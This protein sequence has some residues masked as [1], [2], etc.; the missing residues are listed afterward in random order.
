VIFV[1]LWELVFPPKEKLS[2]DEMEEERLAL[3]KNEEVMVG[4]DKKQQ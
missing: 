3:L 4:A 2:K 1:T